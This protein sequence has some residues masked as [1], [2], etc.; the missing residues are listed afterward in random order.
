MNFDLKFHLGLLAVSELL[1]LKQKFMYTLKWR[2][3]LCA[4]GSLKSCMAKAYTP[5]NTYFLCIY[6]ASFVYWL[7]KL[8]GF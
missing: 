4:R 2:C 3:I 5:C 8:E 1:A 7:Y 6:F